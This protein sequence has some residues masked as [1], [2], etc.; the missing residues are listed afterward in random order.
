MDFRSPTMILTNCRFLRDIIE[1]MAVSDNVVNAAFDVRSS[2]GPQI[3][4]FIDVLT[5]TARPVSHCDL[6]AQ[7]YER[8]LLGHT[9]QYD[10]EFV[11]LGAINY[12]LS[13]LSCSNFFL[14]SVFLQTPSFTSTRAALY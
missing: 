11:V 10:E 13:P 6:S 9:I 2:L 4:P 3:G 1:C 7:Q 14:I 12:S 8:G 5:Y